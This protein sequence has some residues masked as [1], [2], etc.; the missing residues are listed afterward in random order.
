MLGRQSL[1]F[2]GLEFYGTK[3]QHRGKWWVHDRLR[4]WLRAD[5]DEDIEVERGGRR[6]VLN[7][8]DFVHADLFWT[9]SKDRW[10][11]EHALRFLQPGDV[12][13]DVGANFGYYAIT[14]AAALRG[15]CQV[16]AFEPF[17]RNFERLTRHVALNGLEGAVHAHPLGLSDAAGVGQMRTRSDNSGA[18]H[19]AETDTEGEGL[20]T[21]LVTLDEFCDGRAIGRLDFLKIDVEGHEERVLSGG[22][23]TIARHRPRILLELDPPRLARAR[24]S[25]SRVV[26][27]LRGLGYELHFAHRER[28]SPLKKLPEG[29]GYINAFALP[30]ASG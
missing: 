17:P 2:R 18:A 28:L 9:G 1:L 8:S 22:A 15:D 29:E 7:P 10:D 6:W 12:I 14:L 24:S 11:V 19:V 3:V 25:A 23:R 16:H 5:V 30:R 27:Q 21:T 20:P 13:F 4:H 26:E